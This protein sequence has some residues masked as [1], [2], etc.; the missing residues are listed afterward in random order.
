[1]ERTSI[2][3]IT[4]TLAAVS[5]AMREFAP[6]WT[7]IQG[8]NSMPMPTLLVA[9]Q[10]SGDIGHLNRVLASTG[11]TATYDPNANEHGHPAWLSL[12]LPV[13]MEPVDAFIL[14]T[15]LC[16]QSI[17]RAEVDEADGIITLTAFEFNESEYAITLIPF[18][19]QGIRTLPGVINV[20]FGDTSVTFSVARGHKPYAVMQEV[21]KLAGFH[22]DEGL[23]GK[24][25]VARS[26]YW[27]RPVS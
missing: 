19:H 23:H 6:L 24:N 5:E 15:T 17:W 2:R 3:L 18:D 16:P 8:G 25:F 1:M 11:I 12:V 10:S 4:P 7:V 26:S 14:R 9:V 13:G 22:L 20:A 21:A 27:L